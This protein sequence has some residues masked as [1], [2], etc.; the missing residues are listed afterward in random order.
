MCISERTH[1]SSFLLVN[2]VLW[3]IHNRIFGK[4]DI[5]WT[6]KLIILD[7]F[8]SAQKLLFVVHNIFF[9]A[10]YDFWFVIS[11]GWLRQ[12]MEWNAI[13][14]CADCLPLE[15]LF[16]WIDKQISERMI[17]PIKWAVW[18]FEIYDCSYSHKTFWW[19]IAWLY[20]FV[21]SICAHFL[22]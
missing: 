8:N 19:I 22:K 1:F 12:I 6:W 20:F 13:I 4:N 16:S 5:T 18:L 15:L 2:K 21:Y 9:C 14:A 10:L 3:N 11:I 7:S 17:H